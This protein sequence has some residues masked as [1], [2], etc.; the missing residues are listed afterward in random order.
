MNTSDAAKKSRSTWLLTWLILGGLI[1]GL[2]A[3]EALYRVLDETQQAAWADT[4]KWLGGVTFM[5]WLKMILVPLVVSSVVVGVASID[6]QNL[7]RFGGWTLLYY[8]S[9]MVIAVVLGV[10]LVSMVNPGGAV[11]D[12]FREAQVAQFADQ[13]TELQTRARDEK[14]TGE[15]GLV[16]A[17]LGATR[18]I[19]NQMISTNP[20][21]DAAAG[22]LL[23]LIVFSLL[24]GV[25]ISVTGEPA[26]PLLN[27]FNA[28]FLVVM[29]LVEW[30]IWLAPIG[31]FFLVAYTVVSMGAAAL[32]GPLLWY[33]LVVVCG[34]AIHAL[35]ILPLILYLTTGTNPY[36]YMHQM[37]QALMTAFGT[38]SSSATLPV[39]MECAEEYGGVSKKSAGFVLPLG[40]TINM[41]GTALYEAVAVVF[42]F[43]CYGIELSAVQLGII[44]VTA[45]LA[46]VGAAGIPSAG[47]VTMV[48]VVEAVNHSLGSAVPNL[49][50]AAVGIIIGVDR[51]LDMCRTT[52]NVWGDAAG[53]KI[54][55]RLAG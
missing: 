50:L 49:P 40:A 11:P 48:I 44:V 9:T 3:G 32:I 23:P 24:L 39:T 8:G 29:K 2:L 30:I 52:V 21:A 17:V 51:I 7:G 35:V 25:V 10:T 37:R 6:P 19:V 26:R 45:T 31:V 42:L 20:I 46:A 5:N 1:A 13:S 36:V 12:E 15:R 16:S 22:D 34:L 53:A 43:Q 27:V 18:R 47:L 55:D 4:L 54:I 28:L 14:V 33:I 41:D 38:D